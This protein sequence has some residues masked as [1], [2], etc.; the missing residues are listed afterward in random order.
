MLTGQL[1]IY[2]DIIDAKPAATNTKYASNLLFNR[3]LVDLLFQEIANFPKDVLKG[4]FERLN[5][6]DGVIFEKTQ[7]GM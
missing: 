1:G 6:L 5:I 3:D 7:K 2:V 4:R